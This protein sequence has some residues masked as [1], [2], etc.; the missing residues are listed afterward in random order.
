MAV[1]T[2]IMV[3]SRCP[4][5]FCRAA[6]IRRSASLAGRYARGRRW[7]WGTGRGGT[8]PLTCTTTHAW[9]KRKGDWD[10]EPMAV[11]IRP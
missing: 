3:A 9:L 6:V 1:A 11:Q 7:A 10:Y 2:R 4:Y 8:V 5:R